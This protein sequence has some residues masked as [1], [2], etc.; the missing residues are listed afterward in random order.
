VNVLGISDDTR[1]DDKF[2]LSCA[3]WQHFIQ[4]DQQGQASRGHNLTKPET[5]GEF[6]SRFG[7]TANRLPQAARW[8]EVRN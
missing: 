3:P 4:D 2:T 6:L 7:P 5:A 1:M 8:V